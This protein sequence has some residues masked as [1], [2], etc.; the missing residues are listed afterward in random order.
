[1]HSVY[2]FLLHLFW[3][4][5]LRFVYKY[6]SQ[7]QVLGAGRVTWSKFHTETKQF[8][9]D[10]W[11]SLISLCM[12]TDTQFFMPRK[13]NSSNYSENFVC[14]CTHVVSW[15]ITCLGF[16]PSTQMFVR[17]FLFGIYFCIEVIHM[18]FVTCRPPW[19]PPETETPWNWWSWIRDCGWWCSPGW[20]WTTRKTDNGHQ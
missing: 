9:S 20:T 19:W 16:V 3:P 6:W 12:W 1:M 8:W 15:M 2:E 7:L 17:I 13:G 4:V 18:V 11:T 14:H 10:L 5:V